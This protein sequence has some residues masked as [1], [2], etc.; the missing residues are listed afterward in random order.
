MIISKLLQ[1]E[2]TKNA[3]THLVNGPTVPEVVFE[4]VIVVAGAALVHHTVFCAHE[5]HPCWRV[6][7]EVSKLDEETTTMHFNQSFRIIRYV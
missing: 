4:V 6:D 2:E 3:F 5:V 7:I 1:T